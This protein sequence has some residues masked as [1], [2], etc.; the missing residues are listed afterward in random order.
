MPT[1]DFTIIALSRTDPDSPLDTTLMIDYA[2]NDIHTDNRVGIHSLPTASVIN[3][4]HKGFATDGSAPIAIPAPVHLVLTAEELAVSY[5]ANFTFLTTETHRF[6]IENAG[7]KHFFA[8]YR[9]SVNNPVNSVESGLSIDGVAEIAVASNTGSAF[10]LVDADEDSAS[11]AV[12]WHTL[13]IRL[14]TVS[15]GGGSPTSTIEGVWVAITS[16]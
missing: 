1:P 3:H 14:R 15:G 10:S 6:Y 16:P 12:G 9:T 2:N 11:L 5:N 4:A 7:V 8:R 13:E